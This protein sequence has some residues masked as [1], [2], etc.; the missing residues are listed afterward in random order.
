VGYIG[1]VK[2]ALPLAILSATLFFAGAASATRPATPD[3]R[4][5]QIPGVPASPPTFTTFD[6]TV[7]QATEQIGKIAAWDVTMQST[8]CDTDAGLDAGFDACTAGGI[9]EVQSGPGSAI[10]ASDNTQET[11]GAWNINKKLNDVSYTPN[12]ADAFGFLSTHPGYLAWQLTG[13]PGPDYYSVYNCGW[14]VRA[15][16]LY[17]STTGDMSHHA[18]GETCAQHIAMWAGTLVNSSATVMDT[19]PAGWAASGLW[20]WGNTYSADAAMKTTAATIGGQVKAWIEAAPINLS[21]QQWAM[22]GGAP[23]YGVIES[24]MK[25][26]PT[27]L[28]AWVTKYAPMLGGWIDESTP[29]TPNDW[30]DWRNAWNG[31]NMNAQFTSAQVLG[32]TAGSANEAIAKTILTNLVAQA[33]TTTGA[34]PG[35]QQRPDSQSESW[36]TAYMLYFGLLEVIDNPPH[37]SDAGAEG[38]ATKDAG[39]SHD[40]GAPRDATVSDAGSS[41]NGESGGC[42]I[43]GSG[44]ESMV[45]IAALLGLCLL[46]ARRRSAA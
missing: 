14:G 44:G 10:V 30:T 32:P 8:S 4:L 19:G 11:I 7:A 37:G 31:W 5:Y 26:N 39:G 38:G 40:A 18:Y 41:G 13:D 34:I 21:A 46:L 2:H 27:E 16:M 25:E 36:I 9:R 35:S 17:E 12:I 29:A 42:G 3:E 43:A 15:V 33:G 24:Y 20:L 6:L 22:T 1:P 23:Y 28:T 45:P